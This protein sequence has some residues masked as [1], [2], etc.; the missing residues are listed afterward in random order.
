M[1][2]W[3]DDSSAGSRELKRVALKAVAAVALLPGGWFIFSQFLPA[4]IK[5]AFQSLAMPRVQTTSP[6][7]VAVVPA[8]IPASPLMPQPTAAELATLKQQ[9]LQAAN[10]LQKKK[11]LAWA[12]FY[13]APASCEHPA[14]WSAWVECGNQ[15]MRAKKRFE[16]QWATSEGN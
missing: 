1:R 2:A 5:Q 16:E 10:V 4:V 8:R 12:A 7:S 6:R 11:D 3:R 13:S 14:D 9:A 15:Y